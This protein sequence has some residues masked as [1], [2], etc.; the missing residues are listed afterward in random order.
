MAKGCEGEVQGDLMMT[1]AAIPR[2]PGK[3]DD[4]KKQDSIRTRQLNFYNPNHR[5]LQKNSIKNAQIRAQYK[6]GISLA[7]RLA[8]SRYDGNASNKTCSSKCMREI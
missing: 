6:P 7:V 8:Y 3:R 5:M 1:W 2:S 4:Q